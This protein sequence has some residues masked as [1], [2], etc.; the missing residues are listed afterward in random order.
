MLKLNIAT[1]YEKNAGPFMGRKNTTVRTG[2]TAEQMPDFYRQNDIMFFPTKYE[3]FSMAALEAL[4]CG[5]CLVGTEFAVGP[6]M[7]DFDFC[8]R[9][10]SGNSMDMDNAKDMAEIVDIIIELFQKY[11]VGTARAEIH[12][13]VMERFGTE[14][15]KKRLFSYIESCL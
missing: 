6:E 9:I 3:G 2:L 7:S 12:K 15:Y 4:S 14:Q 8:R 11:S 13:V 5:L 1:N 10:S